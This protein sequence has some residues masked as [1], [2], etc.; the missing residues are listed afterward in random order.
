[1]ILTTAR[2]K[3]NNIISD[4]P[5]HLR[6]LMADLAKDLGGVH[7]FILYGGA[8]MDLFLNPKNKIRDLDIAINSKEKG[9][10]NVKDNLLASGYHVIN[11]ERR[12][13]INII[14]LV[15]ILDVQSEK[16]RLDVAFLSGPLERKVNLTPPSAYHTTMDKFDIH[17]VFWRYPELDCVDLYDAFKALETKTM[18]PVY[19]LYEENPFLLINLIINMCAKYNMSLSK[20]IVHKKSIDVLLE[21]IDVWAHPDKFHGHTVKL[22]HYSTILKAISR[23]KN[24]LAFIDDLVDSNILSHTIP[25]LQKPLSKISRT[26][27]QALANAESKQKIAEILFALVPS[28]KRTVLSQRFQSLSLRTWDLEDQQVK[29]KWEVK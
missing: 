17:S 22:A 23:T 20:N 10:Q 6:K 28:D 11:S 1:M 5:D 3:K 19:S 14:D 4:L 24:K 8:A 26:Q 18:R 21:R 12:Y 16:W 29:V 25:E 15:T 9:I 2:I 7:R 13:F 27:K